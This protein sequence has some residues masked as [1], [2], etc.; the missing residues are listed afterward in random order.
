MRSEKQIGVPENRQDPDESTLQK[1]RNREASPTL[2]TALTSTHELFEAL[3]EQVRNMDNKQ[4]S[5]LIGGL[6]TLEAALAGEE[7]QLDHLNEF[8]YRT[9]TPTV[10]IILGWTGEQFAGVPGLTVGGIITAIGLRAYLTRLT[11][12]QRAAV[13]DRLDRCR[14]L[15]TE[16]ARGYR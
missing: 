14:V 15:L 5:A 4:R 9:F 13:K 16:A 3:R 1:I 11:A 8:W 2:H 10:T 12:S 7:S 6:E